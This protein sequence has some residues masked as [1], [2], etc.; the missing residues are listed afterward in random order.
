MTELHFIGDWKLA[1]GLALG[2]ALAVVAWLLYSREMRDR[3]G[4]LRWFL[5]TLRA[6]TVLVVVLT[7]TG[8]VLHHRQTVGEL[9]RIILLVDG[10]GSMD[11][12]DEQMDLPRKMLCAQSLGWLPPDKIDAS[13]KPVAAGLARAQSIAAAG[14]L[15]DARS[16][17]DEFRDALRETQVGWEKVPPAVWPAAREKLETFRTDLLQPATRLAAT[18]AANVRKAQA[19]LAT[20]ARLAAEWEREVNEAFTAL[21]GKSFPAEDAKMVSV[22][23]KFDKSR[24]WQRLETL[25]LQGKEPLLGRLAGQHNVELQALAGSKSQMLWWP[26]GGKAD[27]AGNK[28]PATFPAYAPTNAT[29]DLGGPIAEVVEQGNSKQRI[30]VVLFSDGQ[31]NTG[32]SPLEVAKMLGQRGIPLHTVGV[33]ATQPPRDLAVLDVK[34]PDT[35]P[36]DAQLRGEV[37]LRDDMPPGEPFTLRIAAGGK[38]LWEKSLTTEQR[39]QR[40]VP[41]DFSIKD[42]VEAEMKAKDRDLQY[43]SLGLALE[44]SVPV[45]P[46][47]KNTNNNT[48]VFRLNAMT[49]K[50]KVLLL[51][52]RPRWEFRY[53]R[54][55]FERD[56][57]WE[58]NALLAGAGGEAKPWS[59]GPRA[60][61]FPGN[62]EA[63][64]SYHLIVFGDVPPGQIRGPELDWIREFVERRGG[65][66]IFV[67]GRQEQ[68]SSYA[69]TELGPL[70]PVSWKGPALEGTILR[71]RFKAVGS[72]QAP[73][74]LVPGSQQNTEIWNGLLAPQRVAPAVALPATEVLL[75]AVLGER[76]VPA[77][78]YRRFGA[79]RVLYAGHDESWRWRYNVGDLYHTRFWNQVSKW[80][81]EAPFP[82]QDKFVSLDS[83]P[84]AYQPGET[85]E[86]RVRVRDEEGKSMLQAKAVALIYRDGQKMGELPLAADDSNGGT[87]RARTMPLTPGQYEIR[88]K[89]EGLLEAEMKARTQFTVAAQTGGE[90]G[91]LTCDER[92]LRQLAFHSGGTYFREEETAALADLLKPLSDGRVIESE[93]VLWQS[94]WWFVPIALLLTL[95]WIV[96]KRAGMV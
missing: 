30:A 49:Q 96:R 3:R 34:A 81:M 72:A 85:A 32:S 28:T 93:T 7:L 68:L 10:S 73:M 37:M 54:N 88:V 11:V 70:F 1:T 17:V 69:E 95:E 63:L 26:G 6:F 23:E 22:V 53:L 83:G 45:L 16:A 40:S 27:P 79:G 52:G 50:P 44:V 57:R 94:Y 55:L 12:S 38:T 91:A 25:L 56:E 92:L 14:Q 77:L 35:V 62:R 19:E 64:F 8:P 21:L 76:S 78:V 89:V 65:G 4:F 67:D 36:A 43:A 33:G 60:G 41:F 74:S 42:F 48:R 9:A 75:E 39:S 71:W 24:R 13:L 59:R 82:V 31:H 86:V 80:M 29:T 15:G 47:E 61:Q 66:I 20:L 87:Y 5:P 18:R 46:G 2:L 90:L 58:V 51:D 84:P